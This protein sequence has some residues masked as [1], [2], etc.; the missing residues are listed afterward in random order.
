MSQLVPVQIAPIRKR[1]R[2]VHE[3]TT[4]L[5]GDVWKQGPKVWRWL[6]DTHI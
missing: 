3:E 2:R 1:R 5:V 6:G 4:M